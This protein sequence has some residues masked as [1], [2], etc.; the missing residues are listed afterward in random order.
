MNL[1]PNCFVSVTLLL[2]QIFKC[3]QILSCNRI[4]KCAQIFALF[5]KFQAKTKRLQRFTLLRHCKQ[6]NSFFFHNRGSESLVEKRLQK[7]CQCCKNFMRIWF[8]TK[9]CRV[10]R[11]MNMKTITIRRLACTF[12]FNLIFKY[13]KEQ[14]EHKF[15]TGWQKPT[16]K[17]W[18]KYHNFY[19]TAQRK[20]FNFISYLSDC[21]KDLYLP[22]V[23]FFLREL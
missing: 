19:S 20:H 2:S 5:V 3:S 12:S 8:Y 4:W 21:S 14:I 6:S 1:Q 10:C 16:N 15:P 11:R 23:F 17:G 13:S 22:F 7:F 18:Q 9:L